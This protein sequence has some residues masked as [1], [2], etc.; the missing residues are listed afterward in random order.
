MS[1]KLLIQA[2][3][4]HNLPVSDKLHII[5]DLAEK[6]N[7]EIY[8]IILNFMEQPEFERCKGTLIYALENY[9][10]E[11][12]FEKAIDWLI[13]GGFE[14][15]HGAFN[16]I[17]KIS[18]LSGDQVDNAYETIKTFSTNHQNEKWRTELLNEVLDMFE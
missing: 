2:L 6:K 1:N 3:Q 16:I 18:K 17:N 5:L 12:L 10:P 9:P 7:N 4:E 11:P 8:P 13:H 14:V 15:A